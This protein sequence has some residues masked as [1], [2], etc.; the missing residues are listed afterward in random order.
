LNENELPDC[1]RLTAS[2]PEE[3]QK[4]IEQSRRLQEELEMKE[5]LDRSKRDGAGG[6]STSAGLASTSQPTTGDAA[7][8][9]LPNDK[10]TEND[11][12][13]LIKMGFNREQV[14]SELR[15]FDGNKTQATAALFAKSI[16]F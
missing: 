14:I 6:A 5:A 3:E 12:Q 15:S 16:K 11:V 1:A 8:T 4:L 13:E 2:S 7:T 9:V 10:F